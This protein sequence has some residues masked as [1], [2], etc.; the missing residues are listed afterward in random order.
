MSAIKGVDCKHNSTRTTNTTETGRNGAGVEH[1]LSKQ[2][3]SLANKTMNA[4]SYFKKRTW[5]KRC[6]CMGATV[7]CTLSVDC[8]CHLPRF[9][10]KGIFHDSF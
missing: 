6:E 7:V 9:A 3:T 1:N 10:Y 8:F 4:S 2:G 5:G